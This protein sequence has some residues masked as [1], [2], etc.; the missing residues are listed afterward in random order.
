MPIYVGE[1]AIRVLGGV[2]SGGVQILDSRFKL[3]S[4]VVNELIKGEI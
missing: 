2:D 3:Y 1:L 4:F